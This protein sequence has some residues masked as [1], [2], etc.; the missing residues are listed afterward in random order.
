[1]KE[2]EAHW[3][4]LAVAQERAAVVDVPMP[5]CLVDQ[6]VLAVEAAHRCD[7]LTLE[8]AEERLVIG[9]HLRPVG[10]RSNRGRDDLVLDIFRA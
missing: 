7:V 4:A 8:V 1:V 6:E 5:D 2:V 3:P 10:E 9:T